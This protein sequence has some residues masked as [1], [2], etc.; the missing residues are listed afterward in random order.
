MKDVLRAAS[1]AKNRRP[2]RIGY[3]PRAFIYGL[4]EILL[5]SGLAHYPE[6]PND[7]VFTRDDPADL[8]SM[9]YRTLAMKAVIDL[10]HSERWKDAIKYPSKPIEAKY[11]LPGEQVF[12]WKRGR[13]ARL[14]EDKGPRREFKPARAARKVDRGY[15]FAVVL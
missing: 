1:S 7:A 3:S 6:Q 5:A 2:E 10:G 4:Y 14:T 12:F 9:T 11:V 15:G 13:H 8:R